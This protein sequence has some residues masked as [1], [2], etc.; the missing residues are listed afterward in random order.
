MTRDSEQEYQVRQTL[1]HS[2]MRAHPGRWSE[3]TLRA[4]ANIED[5]INA[6]NVVAFLD[7]IEA[8]YRRRN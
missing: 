3:Q 7:R 2:A 5:V 8:A 4:V 6:S 1:I